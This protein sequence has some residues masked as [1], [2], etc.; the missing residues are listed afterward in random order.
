MYKKFIKW[1]AFNPPT[2][3]SW[4]GW[5]DFR[6][7]FKQ[8]APIR[9]FIA[10]ILIEN[11]RKPFIR[12]KYKFSD[13]RSRLRRFDRVQT[14]LKPG[15]YDVDTRMLHACFSLLTD[16][17]EIEC[18]WMEVVFDKEKLAQFLGPRRFIPRLFRRGIRSRKYGMQH[19]H[20]ETTLADANLDPNEQCPGQ[21]DEA[22]KII[23]LYTWWKDIRPNRVEIEAPNK[24]EIGLEILSDR[25]KKDNPEMSKKMSQWSK[26]SS[27]QDDKWDAEDT[28]MLIELMKIRK[29]LWT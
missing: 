6:K 3:L 2:A 11:I 23:V 27:A 24:G 14:D 18:A 17:V 25:W 29:G 9:Y 7:N 4:D 28:K 22:E 21:A 15:Y 13:L 8:K 26:D 16:Y 1:M 5:D 19:L 10:N 20:W 12:I